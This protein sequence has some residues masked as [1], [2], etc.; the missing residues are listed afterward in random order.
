MNP[1]FAQPESP[2]RFL[3]RSWPVGSRTC[4]LSVPRLR[5][6]ALQHASVECSPTR[7]PYLKSSDWP[8]YLAGRAQAVAEIAAELG[9][10]IAKGDAP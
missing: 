3:T 1:D 10:T 2:L 7:P 9:I 4:T 8:Q 6:G 5:K